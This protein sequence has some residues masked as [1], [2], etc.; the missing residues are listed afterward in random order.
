MRTLQAGLDLDDNGDKVIFRQFGGESS[1]RTVKSGHT[2]IRA[3]QYDPNGWQ[4]PE[5]EELCQTDDQGVLTHYMTDSHHCTRDPD[6]RTRSLP[7]AR[8]TKHQRGDN[9]VASTRSR[10]PRPKTPSVGDGI[11][12]SHPTNRPRHVIV[13]V[14]EW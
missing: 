5:I 8:T 2:A 10:R 6:A 7:D 12:T 13:S 4:L 11:A 9:D 1:S 3:D 14:Q